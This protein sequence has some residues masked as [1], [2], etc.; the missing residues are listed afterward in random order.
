MNTVNSENVGKANF[1]PYQMPLSASNGI[2]SSDLIAKSLPYLPQN[3]GEKKKVL[4]L[5]SLV[6]DL[7]AFSSHGRQVNTG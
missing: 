5:H 7:P 1:R 2:G 4:K 6:I 3:E